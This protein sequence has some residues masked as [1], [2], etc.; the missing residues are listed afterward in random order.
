MKKPQFKGYVLEHVLAYILESSGYSI[1]T[2]VS[3][4]DPDITNGANGLD[5]SGR[6]AK[7]QIDVI[8]D[9]DWVPAF[10]FPTRLIIEAKFRGQ[11]IGIDVVREQIGILTDINE[12][13][14]SA[15]SKDP[16]PRYRYVSAVFSAS[17]FTQPAI[18]LA[19]AHQIQL[20]DMSDDA[21]SVLLETINLFTGGI[22]NQQ[23]ELEKTIADNVFNKLKQ[24]LF[25]TEHE[26]NFD[27]QIDCGKLVNALKVSID[28]FREKVFV[29]MSQSGFMILLYNSRGSFLEYARRNKVHDIT[30]HWNSVDWGKKWIINPSYSPDS[31]KLSFKL[32]QKL[33][34]W[35][36][37]VSE[38]VFTEAIEQKQKHFSKISIYHKGENG[39][40]EVFTL[41]FNKNNLTQLD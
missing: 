24:A 18:D 30:I 10:T 7:H 5:I 19:I 6:G 21:F 29:G 12:N 1:I 20:I 28:N 2:K 23:D 36:Y 8:G 37:K 41:K 40:S 31:Y 11:K 4:A 38:D 15:H 33:H 32:P 13:Y 35:I 3:N 26:I 16:K 22:F 27:Q 17:G 14:F 25:H 34:D 39:E 9:L